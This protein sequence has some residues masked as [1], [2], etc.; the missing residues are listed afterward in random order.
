MKQIVIQGGKPLRGSVEIP[1]AKN[2]ALPLMAAAVLCTGNVE[3]MNVPFLSDIEVSLQIL[4][5]LGCRAQRCADGTVSIHAPQLSGSAIPRDLMEAMRS[6]IFFLAPLL[7]RTGR[8]EIFM[9]GGCELGGRPIDIHLAG[10]EA[11]GVV[12]EEQDSALILHAPH[13]LHAAEFALRFPSVGATETLLMAA[14]GAQGTT[15]LHGVAKEPEVEDLIR[16]LQQAGVGISGVGTSHLTITGQEMLQGVNFTVCPD[17]IVSATVLCAV[18]ACG[19][20][21]LITGG[22]TEHVSAILPLLHTLGATVLSPGNSDLYAVSAGP[23]EGLGWQ[24]T[25][26]YP[27]LPTDAAPL[28]AATAL[29]A[30]GATV[31]KDTVFKNRF[32]C[33]DGFAALGAQAICED[34]T[35]L[36]QGVD[37]LKGAA[38]CGQDLRGTA[39]LVIAALQAQGKSTVQGVL[40]LERGY[41]DIVS[42]FAALGAEIAYEEV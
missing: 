30:K 35:I 13:G 41:E 6:S 39:A 24:A 32:S 8:A 15:V 34:S 14:A 11:M 42:L 28:L 16:F 38:L 40:H 22:C 4:R 1:G 19:G 26:V 23:K 29:R 3:L 12:Q 33:Q 37:A 21:V 2:S 20:E 17:R 7:V 25:G 27:A 31:L 9:P 18:T 5:S 36:I 10:L